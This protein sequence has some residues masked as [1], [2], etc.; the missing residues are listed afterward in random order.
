MY[1]FKRFNVVI[2]VYKQSDSVQSFKYLKKHKVC[3]V[4]AQ[5]ALDL[6]TV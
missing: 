4:I 3:D 2:G 5:N 1:R 6:G